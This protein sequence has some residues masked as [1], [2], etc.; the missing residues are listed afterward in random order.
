VNDA[1]FDFNRDFVLSVRRVEMRHAM[2]VE[3]HT[4]DDAKEPGDFRHAVA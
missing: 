2:L 3:E 4:D 1:R